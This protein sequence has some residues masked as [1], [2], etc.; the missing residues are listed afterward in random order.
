MSVRTITLLVVAAVILA[1][2]GLFYVT[3]AAGEHRS[4]TNDVV[5]RE[6]LTANLYARIRAEATNE[7]AVVAG[8][9]ALGA[10]QLLED[11]EL[12]KTSA[13]SA[14][15]EL[16]DIAL[17]GDPE[18]LERVEWVLATHERV[19]DAYAAFLELMETSNESAAVGLAS[20]QGFQTEV[21]VFLS[22]V[23]IAAE[24][25]AARLLAAQ[26]EDQAA[27]S[28]WDQIVLAGGAAWAVLLLAGSIV[29]FRGV[30]GPIGRVA[31]AT[32]AM[33]GGDLGVRLPPAPFREL[34]DLATSFNS[35]AVNLEESTEKL[36]E[37][38]TT[39]GL[40][41]LL[42]HRSL[43]DELTK[44]VERSRRYGHPVSVLMMD[45]DG[46]KLFN[47]TYGHQAGD[48][49]LRQVA[50]VLTKTGRSV[51]VVGRYG[52]D[53]FMVI[54]PESD[55]DGAVSMARR[56]L[57]EFGQQRVRTE[58]GEDLPLALSI[59]L[60]VCPDDSEH[61]QELLAYADASLYEAKQVSGSS[62][63]ISNAAPGEFIAYRQTPMAVLDSLVQGIDS[64][65]RYTRRHSQ[66]DAEFAVELGSAVGLSQE[67]LRSLRIAGLLHD[68]GKIGVPDHI[69]KKPGPL[70]DEE[71]AMMREHVVLSKLIVQGVPNLQEVADAVHSHHER[72]DGSG[73]PR[74][75]RGEEIPL[76]GRILAVADAYSAMIL[77]RPYRKALSHEEAVAELGRCAGTQ[78]DPSLVDT[79]IHLLESQQEAA[80]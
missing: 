9:Y 47:D 26:R 5:Q 8:Y 50:E 56:V 17:D 48:T 7:A 12:A 11:F 32:R 77:D 6:I 42:N 10:R 24:E 68:V 4:R 74:G 33:A 31:A 36:K 79:F 78:F 49:V 55:R 66:Q 51:D 80:A 19:A 30:L 65:D 45:I 41:G 15:S 16:H 75:L 53:E 60:A 67:P 22:E 44:E 69:L 59:G 63:R 3:Y 61:K 43:Q 73:Y 21:R 70:T 14:L 46:F 13:E 1:T 29:V 76:L 40:T 52:G 57:E 64:K 38:A 35:M 34:N 2:A 39:D 71:R 23:D 20:D 72:W 58:R 27:Q 62:L 54:L 28:R 25:A 37:A 18:E